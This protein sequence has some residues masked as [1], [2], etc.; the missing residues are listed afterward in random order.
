M[1]AFRATRQTEVQAAAGAAKE[2][3][4]QSA[5]APA[6]PTNLGETLFGVK[7]T[8]NTQANPFA[9][10]SSHGSN[11]FSANGSQANPYS[12]ASSL[13]AKPTQKPDDTG[14][15]PETFAQKARIAETAS[16]QPT[17]PKQQ[18]PQEPWPSHSSFL[19]AFPRYY[20]DAD[21]EYIEAEPAETPSNVRVENDAG[22]GSSISAADD[23]TLFESSMDK[24]FQRF[25]DRLAQNPEQVLRYDFEGQ[26]LLYAKNDAVGK[27]FAEA[28][29]N[30]NVKVKTSGGSGAKI[31]KCTNCGAGRVF[32]FQLTPHLITELEAD[33][34][35]IDGMDWGTVIL[36]VCSK[37][38]QQ[39]GK[40]GGE[41]GYVEEWAG[42]Q[43]EELASTKRPA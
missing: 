30:A 33:D 7:S 23:K 35:S 2:K 40:N 20:L 8:A 6:Q 25:A 10:P 11:P 32:E 26:P 27:C 1:R 39:P 43:W 17:Q 3:V 5:P 16:P 15:L 13:A 21:S 28:Q 14:S 38:C 34:M 31:P 36:G 37:D 12:S 41:V 4:R 9:S 42:V 22:E 19:E 29:E 24:T 18:I